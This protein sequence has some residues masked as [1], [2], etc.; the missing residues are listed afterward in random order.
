MSRSNLIELD[1]RLFK[2]PVEA[3]AIV[4]NLVNRFRRTNRRE[5]RFNSTEA[6]NALQCAR[7]ILYNKEFR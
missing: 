7:S 5:G 1:G 2:Q 3:R 6:W 4:Y